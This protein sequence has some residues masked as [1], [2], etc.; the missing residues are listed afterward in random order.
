NIKTE[1]ALS[2]GLL[3]GIDIL[4]YIWACSAE[5]TMGKFIHERFIVSG[6]IP[7][8]LTDQVRPQQRQFGS[9]FIICLHKQGIYIIFTVKVDVRFYC[10][11]VR[12]RSEKVS[13]LDIVIPDQDIVRERPPV[14]QIIR[15]C[16]ISLE[17]GSVPSA[18]DITEHN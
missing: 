16:R 17:N 18:F 15:K 8:Q 9:R 5:I 7:H 1:P 12:E 3:H 6:R 13:E 11:Q 2:Q 10:K 14:F 4:A